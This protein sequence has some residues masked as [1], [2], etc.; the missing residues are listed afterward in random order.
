MN[1]DPL[2][3]CPQVP[4]GFPELLKELSREVLRSQPADIYGFC[5]AFFEKKLKERGNSPSD[6]GRYQTGLLSCFLDFHTL[7][8]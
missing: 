1:A 2:A 6:T 5:T 7:P 8:L 3:N 4:Q